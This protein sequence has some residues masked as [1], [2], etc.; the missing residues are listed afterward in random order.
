MLA[1]ECSLGEHLS[2][3][4]RSKMEGISISNISTNSRIKLSKVKDRHVLDISECLVSLLEDSSRILPEDC[5]DSSHSQKLELMLPMD[6]IKGMSPNEKIVLAI[7]WVKTNEK[8]E[9][10]EVEELYDIVAN[11]QGIELVKSH[12]QD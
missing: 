12:P 2:E 10:E 8:G 1:Q 4:F 5:P 7:Q 9:Q 11:N 3:A 6:S